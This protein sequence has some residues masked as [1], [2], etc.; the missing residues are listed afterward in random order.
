MCSLWAKNWVF[1]YYLMCACTHLYLLK[2]SKFFTF[3]LIF[4]KEELFKSD[5]QLDSLLFLV[6]FF[7]GWFADLSEGWYKFCHLWMYVPWRLKDLQQNTTKSATL[8]MGIKRHSCQLTSRCLSRQLISSDVYSRE[9][10]SASSGIYKL[11]CSRKW[12][13]AILVRQY[14]TESQNLAGVV[15]DLRTASFVPQVSTNKMYTKL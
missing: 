7:V 15:L 14:N 12:R 6:C 1:V 10:N 13:N 3:Q 5:L 11:Q 9:L 4:L 2:K 8:S